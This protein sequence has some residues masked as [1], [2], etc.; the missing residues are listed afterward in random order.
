MVLPPIIDSTIWGIQSKIAWRRA[1]KNK[2]F[3]RGKIMKCPKCG[4]ENVSVQMVTETQLV[5][6]HHG[7]IWW[8]CIGWWW[9]F[10]KWLVFTLPALIVKIFAPKKQKLKQKQKSVCVCQNC[11]Y[12]WEA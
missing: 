5:D 8:I 7:I 12:H 6:K 2:I 9:I 4:S 11:G 1:T 10:I 3:E